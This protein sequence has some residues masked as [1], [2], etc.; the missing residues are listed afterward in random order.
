MNRFDQ[1][2]GVVGLVLLG[3]IGAAWA[4]APEKITV[5]GILRNKAGVLQSSTAMI[6]VRFFDSATDGTQLGGD[7]G[8][9]AVPVNDG[10]FSLTLG[11]ARLRAALTAATA[12]W[13]EVQADKDVYPRQPVTSQVFALVAKTAEN[14]QQ[15]GGIDATGYQRALRSSCTT[16]ISSVAA[17]GTVSCATGSGSGTVTSVNAGAGLSGGPITTSGTLAVVF[18]GNGS[19][20]A[21]ARSDH[22]HSFSCRVVHAHAFQASCNNDEF[23]TGGGCFCADTPSGPGTISTTNTWT[24]G[25]STQA[26]SWFCGLHG[27]K[28]DSYQTQA[29]CCRLQ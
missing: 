15:L 23:L 3:S 28:D 18:G 20:D 21:A 2:I 14:A 17:D 24:A 22:T 19:A 1:W 7:Y 8:P 12:A 25:D 10:L 4:G 27:C 9:V 5:Q 11:D 29:I 16:G 6:T 26:G 13:L